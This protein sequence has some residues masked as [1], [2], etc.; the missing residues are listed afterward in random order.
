MILTCCQ[1]VIIKP[2]QKICNYQ[3]RQ[4]T[5]YSHIIFFTMYNY[6]KK[7]LFFIPYN[8]ETFMMF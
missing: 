3:I 4:Y 7:K 6:K 5:Y 1:Y 2:Y 8:Y